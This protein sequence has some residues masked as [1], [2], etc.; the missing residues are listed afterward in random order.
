MGDDIK[1][2]G[3]INHRL[4][5]VFGCL[6]S[7]VLIAG[8]TSLYLAASLRYQSRQ[9][10]KENRHVYLV[11]QIHITLHHL[12]SSLQ[13][14]ELRGKAVPTGLAVAYVTRLNSLLASY[15]EAGPR[16]QDFEEVRT[17]ITDALALSKTVDRQIRSQPRASHIS[18]DPGPLT[19]L[20]TTE[21]RI[22]AFAHTLSSALERKER[23]DVEEI[24]R[25]LKL[26]EIFNAAFILLGILFMVASS[27]YFYWAIA[28]PLRRL[29]KGAGELAEW[30]LAKEMPVTSTDEIGA[31]SHAFNTMAK[32]LKKHEE[33]FR[34]L[35]TIEERERI[36]QELHD[37]IAQDL[38]L[39][40]LK[41]ADVEKS[42]S[43]NGDSATKECVKDIRK[44]A[45]ASYDEVRQ[46]IFGL[47]TIATKHLQFIPALGEYL[48]DFSQKI[49]IPIDLRVQSSEVTGLSP[50]TEIQLIRIIHEALTNT[51]KHA[52]ATAITVAF[53]RD[54]AVLK[55]TIEDDGKGFVPETVISKRFHFGLQTMKER[56][57]ALGGRLTIDSAPDKGTRIVAVLPLE[58]A[59]YENDPDPAGR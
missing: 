45:A 54:R 51:F 53:E 47:R 4:S 34:G 43:A 5:L 19:A 30:N 23:L 8:G 48:R 14:A 37:S 52:Q 24:Q 41:L 29:A 44:I 10:A 57:E 18:S 15:E 31:L 7:L 27:V 32:K 2:T 46:A 28:V 12:F 1:F 36:A 39:I 22:Q 35:A 42:V 56:A 9:I 58:E 59:P 6:F 25:S 17:T 13:R 40:H 3:R 26:T 11:Q 20:E 16:K 33:R 38:A 21:D 50:L 49:N 55:V